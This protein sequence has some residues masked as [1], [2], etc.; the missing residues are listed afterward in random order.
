MTYAFLNKDK[1]LY[2]GIQKSS[3]SIKLVALAITSRLQIV[4]AAHSIGLCLYGE[5][6]S[7][8]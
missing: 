8:K 6:A 1:L 3:T 4:I 5:K 7:H 2:V